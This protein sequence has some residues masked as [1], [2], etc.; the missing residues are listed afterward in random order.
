MR[1]VTPAHRRR[2][3]LRSALAGYTVVLALVLGWPT[4]VDAPIAGTLR[5]VLGWLHARGVP[6]WVGYGEIEFAANIALFVPVGLLLTLVLRRGRWWVAVLGGCGLS[7]LTEVAQGSLRPQRFAT[8][9]DVVAN[10]LGAV[11]GAG[12]AVLIARRQ[13]RAEE[14][15][16]AMHPVAVEDAARADLGQRGVEQ[17]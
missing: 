16:R 7:L 15:L 9:R 8:V 17:V 6:A 14:H 3:A 5:G 2:R 12:L 13:S 10:T 4:P 11:I 1:S